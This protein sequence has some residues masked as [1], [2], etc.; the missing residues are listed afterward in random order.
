[1]TRHPK[2]QTAPRIIIN[3]ESQ[4]FRPDPS[5]QFGRKYPAAP[6]PFHTWAP[7]S[8]GAVAL[9]YDLPSAWRN[10]AG[11][12]MLSARQVGPIKLKVVQDG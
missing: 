8:F 2:S 1:M 9:A 11:V 4:I 5:V 3:S 6:R 10:R 12:A 7:Y